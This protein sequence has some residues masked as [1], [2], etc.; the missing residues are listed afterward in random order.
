MLTDQRLVCRKYASLVEL[1]LSEQLVVHLHTKD[2]Q[3][4]LNISGKSGK[5]ANLATS[6]ATSGRLRTLLQGHKVKWV[7]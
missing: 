1:P 6:D 3:M 2:G 7:E 4:Q 5:T